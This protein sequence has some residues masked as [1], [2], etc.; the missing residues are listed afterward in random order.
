MALLLLLGIAI[1]FLGQDT[2]DAPVDLR[3]TAEVSVVLTKTGYVP[4]AIRIT[5]GA[6]VTFT[7]DQSAS[8]W[9][10][11]NPHPDHTIYPAFDPMGP[12]AAS[13]SW[14]FV[15]DRIGTWGYHDHLQSYLIGTIY[16]EE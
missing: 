3:H 9:P 12:V 16:V 6:R 15:F 5:K 8:F 4:D 11:S 1:S 14:S 2:A 10:A 13:S 7:T